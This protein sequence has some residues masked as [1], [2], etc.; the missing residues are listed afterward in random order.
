MKKI[1]NQL[2]E[3][4]FLFV[5]IYILL[6]IVIYFVIGL[7]SLNFRQWVFSVSFVLVGIGV[8]LGIIF[9]ILKCKRMDKKIIFMAIMMI[10]ICILASFFAVIY[11]FIFQ[12]EYVVE[13][14]NQ[15]L[16]AYVSAFFDT[17][18]YYYEYK[19][20]LF[21]GTNKVMEEYYGEG[22]FDPIKN[23][24][25]KQYV[26]VTI[27]YYD[28]EGNI[29][30]MRDNSNQELNEETKKENLQDPN[31]TENEIFFTTEG[32]GYY[33]KNGEYYATVDGGVNFTKILSPREAANLAE[34]EATDEK[35]QYQPWQSEFYAGGKEKTEEI[36]SKLILNLDEIDRLYMWEEE[37]KSSNYCGQLMW[38]IRLFDENDPLTSLY[39]YVNAK[40]GEILGAGK[41]SD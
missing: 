40:N 30:E 36:A 12:P 28:K 41:T 32:I 25:E 10:A 4:I 16:V 18:V 2:K 35:Y 19:N 34:Q 13:K 39:I 5:A 14:N 37:W 29:V 27:T 11:A 26:P 8:F 7:L 24:F 38:Q 3:K 33:T 17:Q 23:E 15:K 22:K 20:F 9:Q 31:Q 6:F 1:F 21:V